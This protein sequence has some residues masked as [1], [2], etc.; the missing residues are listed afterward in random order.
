MGDAGK[1][2]KPDYEKD[3]DSHVNSDRRAPPPHAINRNK[4]DFPGLGN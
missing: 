3:H 4:I 2:L 1:G